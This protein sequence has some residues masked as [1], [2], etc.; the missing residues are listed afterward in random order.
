MPQKSNLPKTLVSFQLSSLER[1]LIRLDA[2]AADE[3]RPAV[4]LLL[5]AG[6]ELLGRVE[7]RHEYLRLEL[8][9]HRPGAHRAADLDGEALHD[10]RRRAGGRHDAERRDHLQRKS[11]LGESRRAGKKRYR[12]RDR[13]G[14]Q[15]ARLE[16]R[17]RRGDVGK[18]ELDLPTEQV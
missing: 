8:L 4:A 9:R 15:L 10:R 6:G 13:Q 18:Q 3:V 2:V 7:D 1:L 16:V 17:D 12:L 14:A 11:G 5:E